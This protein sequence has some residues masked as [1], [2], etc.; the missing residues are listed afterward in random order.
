MSESIARRITRRWQATLIALALLVGFSGGATAKAAYD[1]NNAH[2]V[3]GKHA[4][5]SG[6]SVNNRKGKLVATDPDTGRLPNN[7]IGEAKDSKKLGGYTHKQMSSMPLLVQGAGVSGSA[8]A[9]STGVVLSDATPGAMRFGFVVPPDHEAGS[10]LSADIVY[11]VS[12]PAACAWSVS[13]SGLEGPDSP[14]G[15]D[16][17]NGGWIV[18]DGGTDYDGLLQV[19]AGDTGVF[20]ATFVWPFSDDPGQFVQFAL[21]RL[22][23]DAAD[24]CT[25]IVV[26]G[27]QIRY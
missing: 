23:G 21:Q 22:A 18:P 1:A 3:D 15:P 20:K 8:T 26:Y 25:G 12:G 2:K 13:T 10:G 4:V 11:S 5:S 14:T 19:P 9:A 27:A 17:H 24:T 16:L 6:A 7:I